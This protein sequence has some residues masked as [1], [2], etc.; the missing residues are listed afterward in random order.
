MSKV[1]KSIEK[2]LAEL[3]ISEKDVKKIYDRFNGD[4]RRI[5]DYW[6]AHKSLVHVHH[7]VDDMVSRYP[8]VYSDCYSR[9][10]KCGMYDARH[11]SDITIDMARKSFAEQFTA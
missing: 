4:H 5:L 11:C 7:Y 9:L 10:K 8:V 6:K 1:E 2:L 3:M